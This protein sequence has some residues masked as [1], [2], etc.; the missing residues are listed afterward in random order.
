MSQ[1]NRRR[2]VRPSGKMPR[3]ARSLPPGPELDLTIEGL[4]GQGDGVAAGPDGPVFVPFAAPGDRVRVRLGA[5]RGQGRGQGREATLLEVVAA[6]PQRAEP[7]CPHFGACGGC[8]MQHVADAPY[9]AW[10]RDVAIRALARAGFDETELRDRLVAPLA[11]TPPATRRR[12][13]LSARRGRD[14]VFLGFNERRSNHL[15]DLEACPVARPELAAL[16]PALRAVLAEV[17][18]EREA[19]DLALTVLEDGVDLLILAQRSPDLAAREALAGFAESADLARISWQDGDAPA[20]PIAHRRAGIVRFGGVPVVLPPG[21]FLQASGEGEAILTRLVADGVG[22]AARIA[23]LFCGAGTFALP[24]ATAQPGRLV[25]AVD[26]DGPA[27]AALEAACNAAGLAPFVAIARR[28]LARDPLEGGELAGLDAAIFDPPRA[29]AAAQAAALAASP[30]PV[31]V[32]VSCN[33]ASF[34]RDAALLRDGGY[35]LDWLV[36]VDQF[37]WS[38]H[39]ELVA[40]FVRP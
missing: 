14:R 12:L 39:V 29:G 32:A 33:P 10:K 24:L 11:T 9:R 31:V 37:L 27:L 17:L 25:Q 16:L 2:S 20:E 22:P 13:T 35:R 30:V 38:P 26:G 3:Q 40:R 5:A 21:G 23:D 7:P 8:L 4:G 19:V 1:S 18:A 6:G 36:P 15:I 28:N 34:A